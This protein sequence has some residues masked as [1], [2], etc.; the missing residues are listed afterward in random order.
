MK[1]LVII[2]PFIYNYI[3]L[4]FRKSKLFKGYNKWFI[5]FTYLAIGSIYNSLISHRNN[6]E[7]I[8]QIWAFFTPLIFTLYISLCTFISKRINNRDFKLHLRYSN[9]IDYLNSKRENSKTTDK[10]IS[11]TAIFFVLF[12][13]FIVTIFF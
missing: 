8:I 4:F 7:R 2:L 9:E 5:V 12:L 6:E 1:F 3:F 10:I 13:P 11:Y